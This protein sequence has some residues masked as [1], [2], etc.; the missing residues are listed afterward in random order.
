MGVGGG[1]TPLLIEELSCKLLSSHMHETRCTNQ[2]IPLLTGQHTICRNNTQ[3]LEMQHQLCAPP[4][5]PPPL[6]FEPFGV[7]LFDEVG[8]D[9]SCYELGLGDDVPQHW[10][11]VVD[12]WGEEGGG[13]ER[14]HTQCQQSVEHCPTHTHR[15]HL[16]LMQ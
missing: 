14:R 6:T 7:D 13:R 10:D 4:P 5:P 1:H 8:V 2:L 3:T 11:I 16:P 9:V 15:H 12:T